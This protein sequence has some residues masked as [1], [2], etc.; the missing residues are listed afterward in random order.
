MSYLDVLAN[1]CSALANNVEDDDERGNLRAAAQRFRNEAIASELAGSLDAANKLQLLANKM[2]N[3]AAA[4]SSQGKTWPALS[5]TLRTIAGALN[6][7]NPA[8]I[9][10]AVNNFLNVR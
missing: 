3:Q 7:F 6:P 4:I 1:L 10:W 9:V 8:T 2:Q 5:K